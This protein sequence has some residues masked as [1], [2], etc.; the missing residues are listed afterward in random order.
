MKTI[1]RVLIVIFAAIT[2]AAAF[3]AYANIRVINIGQSYEKNISDNIS[4]DCIIVPGAAVYGDTVSYTLQKRLDTAYTLYSDGKAPK[5]IVSGD[6]GTKEY[7]EVH[8][9]RKYLVEKGVDIEDVFMD[10][11]GFD[12][13][14]SIYR[15]KAV[16]AAK[17]PIIVSQ[18]SH[19]ARGAYI[20]D[21]LNM[22]CFYIASEG[23]S[24]YE[25][26][27]QTIRESLARVKAFLQC[28]VFHSKPKYLGEVIPVSGSGLVTE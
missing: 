28:E 23:Y 8:A 16:F 6:H 22:P 24:R 19:A 10:H 11:A 18:R 5:I 21:R 1:K 14:D 2:A 25:S 13:Y 26:K 4:G 15:A 3:F 20:A 7:N 17:N 27:F 9:M 12:T